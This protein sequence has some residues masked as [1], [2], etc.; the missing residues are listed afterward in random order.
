MRNPEA[1][2]MLNVGILLGA[3]WTDVDG[4]PEESYLFVGVVAVLAI[5]YLTARWLVDRYW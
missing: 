4:G 2:L 5:S 3:H 1:F